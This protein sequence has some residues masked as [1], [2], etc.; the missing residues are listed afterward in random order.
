LGGVV[1]GER[2]LVHAGAGGVGMAAVQVA[3]FL[4]AEVFATASP[5]KWDVLRGLGLD[6]DHIGSSR[7]LGFVEVVRAGSGGRGVDVVLN[8]L[9]GEFV[10][11]SLG[12]LAGGGRFLEMGKTDVRDPVG[13]PVGLSVGVTYRAFDLIE[14]GPERIGVMLG[15]V[16]GLF[17]AGRVQPLPVRCWDVRQARD[18]FRYVSQA[19]HVGKVV[20]TVPRPVD[21]DGTV[22]V[23]GGTGSLGGLVARHLADRY[24]V[25]HVLL[26]SR[27]GL[28]APGADELV[29]QLTGSGVQVRVWAGDVADRD[30]VAAMLASVPAAHPVTAVVHTAG[31]IDDGLVESQTTDRLTAVWAP[32]ADAAR[33]LHE[34]THDLD[35]AAF[36]LFSST[37]AILGAPGQATYAAANNYLNALATH[38]HQHGL[39]ATSL[40]WGPWHQT[41]TGMTAHLTPTDHD[42]ILRTGIT[43]LTPEHGLTLYDTATNHPQPTHIPL[44]LNPTH[45][46]HTNH[47]L[48]PL[49]H[50]L[51]TP[52]HPTTTPAGTTTARQPSLAERLSPLSH[53]D[54]TRTLLELVQTHAVA[55]LGHASSAAV[56]PDRAFKDL[57]FDSL[58]SVELRNRLNTAT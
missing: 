48:P 41:H 52:P 5:G 9:A 35:L 22:V 27:R 49:L 15:E 6:D 38:R 23:T 47:H 36:I 39:P 14:A 31:I 45:L 53:T 46:H 3:R 16:L 34:L 26:M 43:P 57:G 12:L 21:P 55:V 20:L 13:L 11:A 28:T 29:Q 37:S 32:K 10:D 54:Q 33:H 8:S 2:V 30:T 4:G 17:A 40:A 1:A 24:G 58:T 51:T 19:R 44:H 50:T 42:R 18:A 7:D 25:K 56:D